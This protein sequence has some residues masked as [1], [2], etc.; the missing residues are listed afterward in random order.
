MSRIAVF[1]E[2][3]LSPYGELEVLRCGRVLKMECPKSGFYAC[4]NE[5]CPLLGEPEKFGD[6][7]KLELCDVILMFKNFVDRRNCER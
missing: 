1:D 6:R 5:R 3:R 2:G 4:C 7:F